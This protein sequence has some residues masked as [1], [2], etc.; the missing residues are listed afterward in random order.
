MKMIASCDKN[1][2]IGKNNEL[3]ISIPDDM[4]FFRAT[5]MGGV[6][7]MGRKT[8]ESF[9]NAKPLPHRTNIVLTRKPDYEKEG[10]IVVHNMEELDAELAKYNTDDVFVIGGESIYRQLKDRCDTAYITRI[11]Y[12]YDADAHFPNLDEDPDWA[13]TSVSDENFYFDIIYHFTTYKRK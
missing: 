12:S 4:A 13:L 5:T 8:L 6:V 11:D 3:L 7:V 9:R 2:G 10:A 1:W